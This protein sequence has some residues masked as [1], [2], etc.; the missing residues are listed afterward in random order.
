MAPTLHRLHRHWN[1]AMSGDEDELAVVFWRLIVRAAVRVRSGPEAARQAP[2]QV[3]PSGQS[4]ARNSLTEPRRL[5]RKPADRSSLP[6]EASRTPGSS[7]MTITVGGCSTHMFLVD[8]RISL[9]IPPCSIA[10]LSHGAIEGTASPI[11]S[12]GS[13]PSAN[14]AG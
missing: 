13:Q 10:R 9:A 4:A 8:M 5:T 11:R 3:G 7:S 6:S 2:G 1:V 14:W 12:D